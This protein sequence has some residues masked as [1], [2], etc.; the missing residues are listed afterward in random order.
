MAMCRRCAVA[1]AAALA[2]T[3]FSAKAQDSDI[4]AGH[5]FAN[6]PICHL[7][8]KRD[9]YKRQIPTQIANALNMLARE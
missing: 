2:V 6:R 5:A 3:A 1:L 7:R 4:P 9:I 8:V